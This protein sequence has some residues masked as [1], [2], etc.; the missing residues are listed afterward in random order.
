L[1]KI[2]LEI[3]DDKKIIE[4]SIK[5]VINENCRMNTIT[6]CFSKAC[7]AT[8]PDPDILKYSKQYVLSKKGSFPFHAAR[9]QS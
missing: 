3:R 7:N 4:N 6:D 9:C 8:D 2:F 5:L 1:N